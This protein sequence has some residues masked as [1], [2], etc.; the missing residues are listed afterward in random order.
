MTSIGRKAGFLATV[1]LIATV[2]MSMAYALWFEDL[3]A[4]IDVTTGTLDGALA[5]ESVGDNESGGVYESH[6]ASDPPK[7]F[8]E[9]SDGPGGSA[10]EWTIDVSGAYPGYEFDC[11][12]VITNT[13]SIPWHI[14]S[15]LI[16]VDG[17]QID[18]DA[19]YP[20]NC[21]YG[22]A[23]PHSPDPLYVEIGAVEGCQV[24]GNDDLN[25]PVFIGVNEA[26]GAL[27]TYTITFQFHLQQWN[28]SDWAGCGAPRD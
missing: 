23:D 4:N 13:G 14:E 27:T 3:Q 20:G 5:C 24:H 26:A 8:A 12:L 2:G 10:H 16:V 25:V 15:E 28:V 11:Q 17:D 18:C 21:T 22:T 9:V 19:P 1:A 7:D 6:S